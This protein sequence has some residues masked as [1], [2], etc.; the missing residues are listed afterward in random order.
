M[1]MATGERDDKPY[2]TQL[3]RSLAELANAMPPS[4]ID[5]DVHVQVI[6]TAIVGKFAAV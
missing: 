4:V 1:A 5:F 2:L 3:I 6:D